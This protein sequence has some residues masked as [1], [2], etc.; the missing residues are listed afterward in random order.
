MLDDKQWLGV[1]CVVPSSLSLIGSLYLI[2]TISFLDGT[3]ECR[4]LPRRLLVR[5]HRQF[6][7]RVHCLTRGLSQCLCCSSQDSLDADLEAWAYLEDLDDSDK[8]QVSSAEKVTGGPN[9][10]TV[11]VFNMALCDLGW[12]LWCISNFFPLIIASSPLPCSW[13]IG[14]FGQLSSLGSFFWYLSIAYKA[15]SILLVGEGNKTPKAQSIVSIHLWVWTSTLTL[16]VVPFAQQAYGRVDNGQENR[17]GGRGAA[18]CWISKPPFW[19][20]L[21][22]P[23]FGCVIVSMFLCIYAY[24]KYRRLG[25][26][27]Q[28]GLRRI[29][30][31]VGAFFATWIFPSIARMLQLAGY[32]RTGEVPPIPLWLGILHNVGMGSCGI[33]N[34]VVWV[35]SKPFRQLRA[36]SL[37]GGSAAEH[38]PRKSLKTQLRTEERSP[39]EAA[40]SEADE[41]SDVSDDSC[42]SGSYAM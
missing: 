32:M 42:S 24:R 12:A 3:A 6:Q 28:N 18:E 9:V 2:C 25:I 10:L 35:T 23:M 21:Y 29:M 41:S 7:R 30:L 27:N 1:A 34:A 37:S 14:L 39:D 31:F 13:Y 11:S 40:P 17:Q 26:R 20:T 33:G 36:G 16:G 19:L 5:I 4:K 15:L 8:Y 22:G 38:T